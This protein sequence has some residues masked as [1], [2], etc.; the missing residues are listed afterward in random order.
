M[1]TCIA[2]ITLGQKHTKMWLDVFAPT[3]QAYA[4]RHGYDVVQIREPIDPDS[5]KPPQWQKLLLAGHAGLN[6]YSKIVYLDSDVMCNPDAPAIAEGVPD[7]KIGAVTWQGSYFNDP[8]IFDWFVSSWRQ[9]EMKFIRD[10]GLKSF[11]DLAVMG[12]YPPYNDWLNSGVMVF[13]QSHA[14][15][16]RNIY[17][18]EP[19][20][21]HSSYEQQALSY[22]LCKKHP[23]LLHP[24]DRRFNQI[25]YLIREMHYPFIT[26]LHQDSYIISRCV[27]AALMGNHFLHFAAGGDRVEAVNF[28]KH[29]HIMPKE[30]A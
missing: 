22:W 21:E 8:V 6:D 9:N 7:G 11:A 14:E 26:E 2:V 5:T 3:V 16:F 25:W 15:F 1:K 10:A 4:D 20:S 29:S 13:D 28:M 17:E 30:L 23:D 12:G 27:L 18:N 24:L 19:Q